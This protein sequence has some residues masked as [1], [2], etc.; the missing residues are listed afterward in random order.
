ML[1]LYFGTTIGEVM[2]GFAF[3]MYRNL[4]LHRCIGVMN[5]L[6]LDF[7]AGCTNMH[8]YCDSSY[9]PSTMILHVSLHLSC[10]SSLPPATLCGSSSIKH[11][12]LSIKILHPSIPTSHIHL[13]VPSDAAGAKTWP[14]A[15]VIKLRLAL[16]PSHHV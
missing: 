10:P 11:S 15:F 13:S 4:Y 14:A 12:F 2:V 3:K 5:L 1:L 9:F 16:A 8:T 6:N 7:S